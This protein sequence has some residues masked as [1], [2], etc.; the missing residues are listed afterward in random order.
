MSLFKKIFAASGLLTPYGDEKSLKDLDG[1]VDINK[2]KSSDWIDLGL[3]S[4][5]L[6]ATRNVG[7]ASPTDDGDCYFW[8]SITPN[9]D[10]GDI[11]SYAYYKL[12]VSDKNRFQE[13]FL[14]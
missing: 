9:S 1:L 6:W 12:L 4:G 14:S 2:L 13:S 10:P 11:D 5:L 3:P 8:G 7:A